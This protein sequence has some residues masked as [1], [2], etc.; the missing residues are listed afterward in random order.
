[1]VSYYFSNLLKAKENG[2]VTESLP[3]RPADQK[4]KQATTILTLGGPDVGNSTRRSDY[5]I[6]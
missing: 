6:K 2:F 5:G 4:R 3:S 1:V